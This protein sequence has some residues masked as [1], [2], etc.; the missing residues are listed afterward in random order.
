MHIGIHSETACH[1]IFAYCYYRQIPPREFVDLIPKHRKN[2][3][4]KKKKLMK[5]RLDLKK[6]I[7]HVVHDT[8]DLELIK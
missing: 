7:D 2:D 1:I 8:G 6:H 4:S 5:M 3:E